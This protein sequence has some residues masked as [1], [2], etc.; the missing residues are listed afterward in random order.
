MEI[1]PGTRRPDG[2]L[3]CAVEV[4]DGVHTAREGVAR[5][6]SDLAGAIEGG[7]D[8]RTGV[9]VPPDRHTVVVEGDHVVGGWTAATARR[10]HQIAMSLGGPVD[11]HLVGREVGRKAPDGVVVPTLA[12]VHSLVDLEARLHH[13]RCCRYDL[14]PIVTVPVPVVAMVVVAEPEHR[15]A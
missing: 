8:R 6:P 15:T 2:R 10:C 12:D 1:E 5:P 13:S 11:G 7:V 9:L 14:P 4:A 3:D